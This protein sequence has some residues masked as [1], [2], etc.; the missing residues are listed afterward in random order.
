MDSGD[1]MKILH[2][3]HHKTVKWQ[4]TISIKKFFFMPIKNINLAFA[5]NLLIISVY[6][7]AK[8]F[9]GDYPHLAGLLVIFGHILAIVSDSSSIVYN[10]TYANNYQDCSSSLFFILANIFSII[11]EYKEMQATV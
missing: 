4:R 2:P 9:S 5:N 6:A 7:L 8:F 10:V 11:G 1:N 3:K